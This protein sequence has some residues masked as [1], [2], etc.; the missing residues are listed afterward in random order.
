MRSLSLLLA[1]SLCA[2]AAA[3]T[4]WTG[5]DIGQPAIAGGDAWVDGG[6]TITAAGRDIW[7]RSDEGR[8]VYRELD[9]DGEIF[10]R[11]ADLQHAHDW[12]KAGVMIRASLDA[13]SPHAYVARTGTRGVAFQHRAAAGGASHHLSG[14]GGSQ[15]WLRL[16]RTGDRFDAYRSADGGAWSPIGSAEIPMPRTVLIGLAVTSHD[17]AQVATATFDGIGVSTAAVDALRIASPSGGVFGLGE[18]IDLVAE[19]DL[20]EVAEVT[21]TVDGLD[22]ASGAIGGVSWTPS[23]A[24]VHVLT[25][26]ADDGAGGVLCSDPVVVEVTAL[27]VPWVTRPIGAVAEGG[28]ASYADGAFEL[29]NAGRDIWER[30]DAFRFVYQP[31][32]GDFQLVAR[33]GALSAAHDW[34]KAGLMIRDGTADDARH[35]MV[36]LTGTRGVAFQH[37]AERGGNSLH[38]NAGAASAPLWLKLERRGDVISTYRSEDGFRWTLVG[39]VALAMGAEPLV[40]LA[41]TSHDEASHA[42]ATFERTQLIHLA[43]E[44]ALTWR[45]PALGQI[46]SAGDA[47]PLL[48]DIAE[49]A[50]VDQVTFYAGGEVVAGASGDAAVWDGA[51]IGVHHLLAVAT[52]PA[53]VIGQSELREVLVTDLPAPWISEPVGDCGPDGAGTITLDGTAALRNAGHDIWGRRDAFRFVHRPISGDFRIQ[54]R[55]DGLT[56]AHAWTKAGLMIR[57]G[58][59]PSMPHALVAITGTRGVALQGRD[60]LDASS[61]HLTGGA[62]DEPIWLRLE[63]RGSEV[64]ALR[65]A[66]GTLWSEIG[67]RDWAAGDRVEVGLALTSHDV[68]AYADASFSGISVEQLDGSA[69]PTIRFADAAVEIGEGAASPSIGL[70][71][72]V[73]LSEPVHVVIARVGGNAGYDEVGPVY[74]SCVIPAGS[75]AASFALSVV[76]DQLDE[77]D[78]EALFAIVGASGAEI[79]TPGQ[80][81]VTVIDDDSANLP[82]AVADATGETDEDTPLDLALDAADPEGQPLSFRV[83]SGPIHGSASVIDQAAGVLRYIPDPDYHGTDAFT[84]VASDGIAESEPALISV[85]V[86]PVNDAPVVAP[87]QAVAVDEDGEWEGL[88]VASDIDLDALTFGVAVAAQ[89]GTVEVVDEAA[90]RFR[91]VPS[92][93]YNGPDAFSI[94]VSDGTL[95]SGPVV[96]SVAV[97]PVNDP[98]V[99]V[100]GQSIILEE[101]GTGSLAVEVVDVDG[102]ATTI[103]IA[104][105]ADAGTAVVVDAAAGLVEYQAGTEFNGDDSFELI[106]RDAGS[107]SEATAIAV[108][109]SA[110]NDRPIADAAV[111]A[112]D[113]DQALEAQ[114]SATDPDGDQLTYAIASQAT[115]GHVALLD[116]YS[117]A[118]RY[119]PDAD[120]NGPDGFT[121]TAS[122]GELTSLAASV[123]IQ[124][125]PV[126][127]PPVAQELQ[128]ALVAGESVEITLVGSDVEGDDLSFSVV[129][130]PSLGE[131]T[132]T[133]PNLTYT[134]FADSD[135]NDA[136]TYRAN[137][138]T[139]DGAPAIVLLNVGGANTPPENRSAAGGVTEEDVP[140]GLALAGRDADDDELTF[141]VTTQPA[142]GT[143][144]GA[145]TDWTY[146]PD[147]DFN[148]EDTFSYTISDA[149]RTVGPFSFAI[150]VWP[151]NDEPVVTVAS[152]TLDEDA[153]GELPIT[154]ADADGDPITVV[155]ATAP[156]HGAVTG[157]GTTLSYTPAADYNGPDQ[158]EVEV[159]DSWGRYGPFLVPV[160]VDP[161]QD[162]PVATGGV[163]TVVEDTPTAIA[164][165]GE[166]ADGEALTV[167][168]V[169][170]PDVGSIEEVG[171]EWI[172]TPEPDQVATA[173][174]AYRVSDGIDESADGVLSIDILEVFDPPVAGDIAVSVDEDTSLSFQGELTGPESTYS[175]EIASKPAN[176]TLSLYTYTR[177]FTYV[178]GPDFNGNDS[179]TYVGTGQGARSEPATVTITVNPVN[180][181]PTLADASVAVA[182]GVATDIPLD[183]HDV[184]GD[185]LTASI[186]TGPSNGSASI[187]GLVLRYTSTDG[188]E[189]TDAVTVSVSDGAA[190]ASATISIGVHAALPVVTLAASHSSINEQAAD[191]AVTEAA[192]DDAWVDLSAGL[193]RTWASGDPVVGDPIDIGFAFP[194]YG[195]S[196][197]QLLPTAYG[198]VGFEDHV[199]LQSAQYEANYVPSSYFP[200]HAIMV[201]GG[202][203]LS[204]FDSG[205]LRYGTVD[206]S[207]VLQFV[208][209]SYYSNSRSTQ[210]ILH[211][212][213][214]FEVT[215]QSGSYR[216][217]FASFQGTF[218]GREAWRD[219]NSSAI[220]PRHLTMAR[221]EYATTSVLR[222]ET[223]V[224]FATDTPVLLAYDGTAV[225][226]D[227]QVLPAQI[228][229]PAFADHGE[230]AITAANDAI[231]EPQ[232]SA[233][234][235]LVTDEAYAVGGSSVATITIEDD[236]QPTIALRLVEPDP[237]TGDAA[238]RRVREEDAPAITY[239]LTRTGRADIPLSVALSVYNYRVVEG[240]DY[241]TDLP[242]D[243]I[244]DFAAGETVKTF[245]ASVIDDDAIDGRAYVQFSVQSGTGYTSDYNNR[246]ARIDIVDDEQPILTAYF[247]NSQVVEGAAG[248]LY[249][250]LVDEGGSTVSMDG[251]SQLSYI[252]GGVGIT[253]EDFSGGIPA[254]TTTINGSRTIYVY[255]DRD[256]QFEPDETL[257]MVVNCLGQ[258]VSVDLVI[259]DFDTNDVTNYLDGL[260]VVEPIVLRNEPGPDAPSGSEP[261]DVLVASQGSIPAGTNLAMRFTYDYPTAE[262][263]YYSDYTMNTST[264][265]PTIEPDGSTMR[266][267]SVASVLRDSVYEFGDIRPETVKIYCSYIYLM[268]DGVNLSST[269]FGSEDS[270][271]SFLLSIGEEKQTAIAFD[272]PLSGSLVP[273]GP[274]TLT[275]TVTSTRQIAEVSL[276]GQV[277]ETG[278][279]PPGAGSTT[280]TLDRADGDS[281]SF[282]LEVEDVAGERAVASLDL[283]LLPP[284]PEVA[285]V[286]PV[287]TDG[288]PV[289]VFTEKVLIRAETNVNVALGAE[290]EVELLVDGIVVQTV[291]APTW[292]GRYLEA[293]LDAPAEGGSATARVTVTW[294]EQVALSDVALVFTDLGLGDGGISINPIRIIIPSNG[295]FRVL[296]E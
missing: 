243:L 221:S 184:D 90:G 130:Q 132:G 64:I 263:T 24:G 31:V 285:I 30:R 165:P 52:G 150:T 200:D 75:N 284:A 68:G 295:S 205:E 107:A 262:A 51:P 208:G 18:A 267:A 173:S 268:K 35:A 190:S 12:T 108:H 235:S 179:F 22:V 149:E 236:D 43:S 180:D 240:E 142:N 9:G 126:N 72:D 225:A 105:Q 220:P 257:T 187:D 61:Q 56:H 201:G 20:P 135:G 84:V 103:E 74:G 152:L 271:V 137:D 33:I 249:V 232:E 188:Y 214:D 66:D 93:D 164:F 155:V 88:L 181:L 279:L 113:E 73:V 115:H 269:Y 99:I 172:Y 17:Q 160:V 265:T 77:T 287:S 196:F 4:A 270:P 199:R 186:T 25:C 15:V 153:T 253:A 117:G 82:P 38:Q 193:T 238:N 210:L 37:R 203:S 211:P 14:G 264:L 154:V 204:L 169:G 94:E 95:G 227:L 176:G 8:L 16:V 67:R 215:I 171:G 76:D 6:L 80:I 104:S 207:F 218:A 247:N 248:Y 192:N 40:G 13:G 254:G 289:D 112:V 206:G 266:F 70:V 151:V 251:Y 55:V 81:A 144:T 129:E 147:P 139:D 101:G 277:I 282:T 121:F 161:A 45:L 198:A 276:D 177:T 85:T 97:A 292:D 57:A 194:M 47:I 182:T 98:P 245:T 128:Y 59:G 39:Q 219:P 278:P 89:R 111:H 21:Y 170:E 116:A 32:A 159:S 167:S 217:G 120:F 60:Q 58:V 216:Y 110:V 280:V 294:D 175:L 36:V 228:V 127:D 291:V 136:F 28:S 91:Y 79:G 156:M 44:P 202:N 122:D 258:T 293:V 62:G 11:V 274:T 133:L 131:L 255:T 250:R 46:F 261:F 102:D 145:G 109:I 54:A 29:A 252:G 141:A 174:L 209:L 3:A 118:F 157:S 124:V 239:E 86:L 42:Q 10:A 119:V 106:A 158:V 166:D 138:G 63:R 256:G 143:L 53:G 273:E 78:E 178:P 19:C 222:A 5:A 212:D 231:S 123:T 189:G 234:F 259:Q 281:R 41:L 242:A 223:T 286:A 65:S 83:V 92:A 183:A 260:A 213:G 241:T 71:S 272:S 163:V 50:V 226:A 197:T 246:Y 288:E 27:P 185:A 7:N 1:L 125:N 233:W 195:G 114:L 229:I 134:A 48:V 296:E 162:A 34:T 168:F 96:V 191:Y 275:Y 26:R 87:G 283:T 230:V 2:T 290:A 224:P 140:L 244:V 237:L 49:P 146:T 69:P 23:E 100:V 148:G